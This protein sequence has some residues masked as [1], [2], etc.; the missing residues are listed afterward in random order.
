MGL[1]AGAGSRPV[2]ECDESSKY[3]AKIHACVSLAVAS[4]PTFVKA[5]TEMNYCAGNRVIRTK[6]E[7]ESLRY[8]DY[9]R[10]GGLTIEVND[11]TADFYSMN[12]I[13]VIEGLVD[14]GGG[15]DGGGQH[16]FRCVGS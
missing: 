15:G 8:C 11:V 7:L 6:Q 1:M 13:D 9:I 12:N 14:G 16:C 4:S 5:F 10:D 3:F 2:L